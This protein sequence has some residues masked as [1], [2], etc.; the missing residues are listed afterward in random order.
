[1][2]MLTL[3]QLPEF[4]KIDRH[5]CTAAGTWMIEKLGEKNQPNVVGFLTVGGFQEYEKSR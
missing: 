4:L 5:L 3:F 1:M 2:N